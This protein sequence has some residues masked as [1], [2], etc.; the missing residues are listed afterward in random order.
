MRDQ[1]GNIMPVDMGDEEQFM[2][3]VLELRDSWFEILEVEQFTWLPKK[4]EWEATRTAAHKIV[5]G[6]AVQAQ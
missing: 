1:V 3:A 5:A 2:R 4:A 6:Q